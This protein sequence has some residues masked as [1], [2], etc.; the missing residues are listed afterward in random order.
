M[1]SPR[2]PVQFLS[3]LLVALAGLGLSGC[4][5]PVA[6]REA[7][8]DGHPKALGE[9]DGRVAKGTWTRFHADG[10]LASLGGY[11]DGRQSGRWLYGHPGGVPAGVGHFL[12]GVQH[13][14]WQVQDDAGHVQSAGLMVQGQRVGSWMEL[15]GG[16]LEKITYP[17][18][19]PGPLARASNHAAPPIDEF[20]WSPT[21]KGTVRWNVRVPSGTG[22]VVEATWAGPGSPV[23]QLVLDPNLELVLAG[24]LPGTGTGPVTSPAAP[25]PAE[26]KALPAV[27]AES[28]ATVES[29]AQSKPSPAP[30][31]TIELPPV[32]A[33]V[34]VSGIA[35][36]PIPEQEP[37][38]GIYNF[39]GERLTQGF[40][41]GVKPTTATAST[42]AAE[43]PVGDPI[44]LAIVGKP[45]PQTRFLDS[46]GGVIDLARPT[47]TT[48]LI[49]MRGFSNS[50]CLYCSSQTAA[51]IKMHR[52]FT[53]AGIDIM[54]LY[55]GAADSVP[56][57]LKS[58]HGLAKDGEVAPTFPVPVLLDVNLQLVRGLQI[59]DQLA[60]PTTL[61]VNPDGKVT[62]AYVGRSMSDRPSLPEVL[63]VA[64]GKR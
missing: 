10:S 25:A 45:L 18:V 51:V 2:G 22:S 64:M 43:A 4:G 63:A 19:D 31:P 58:A 42:L 26:A 44:G 8:Q 20:A 29:P 36:S 28:P 57:F 5:G 32:Q 34:T 49:I 9:L 47:R 54:I 62:W 16:R 59:E 60:R 56:A 27:V 12:S 41:D 13:G 55:P 7:Y 11:E 23:R 3:P 53:A 6:Y 37:I 15:R 61:I 33:P 38:T 46:A 21:T 52:E 24:T 48:A 35:I 14:W 50:I 39:F 17:E 40:L 30:V 1:K